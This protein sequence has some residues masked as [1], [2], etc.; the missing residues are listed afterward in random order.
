MRLAL[1]SIC[2]L[3]LIGTA[4]AQTDRGTI[5]GT[6]ADPTGAMIGGATIIA[7]NSQTA[8]EYTAAS[9]ATGNYTLAQLPAGTYEI[10]ASMSGFKK[11]VRPG[12]VVSVAQVVRVDISLEVGQISEL[13]T[14]Q[15][16]APLLKTESGEMS[17][18]ISYDR[19]DNL[20][21]ITLGG[22]AGLG[23]IRNPLQVITLLP[24]SS[25][26]NDNT[27][28]ING[29]PSSS[30]AIRIE[31]QD[32]T[33]GMWRQQNQSIQSG[34]DAI[35]EVSI[36]TSNFAAEYGQA[37]GGYFNYTMKSGTNAVHGSAYDY[38]VNEAYNAG[39]PF[40]NDGTG[41]HIK[42]RQRRND[43]G[44]T[45]GGPIYIPKVYNGKDKSFFFFNFEQ[46][47][48][49]QT[50]SN[51][52]Q[53]MPTDAYRAGDF[54]AALGN[55]LTKGGVPVVD[56][57]GRP[58][59]ENEI[60]NPNSTTTVNGVTVRN[61]FMGCNNDPADLNKICTNPASPNYFPLD[62]VAVKMQAL[63]PE[64]NV[65]NSVYNNYNVPSYQN[66]RHTTITSFK[67]DHSLSSKIKLSGYYSQ[68]ITRSPS[69]NG[70]DQIFSTAVPVDTHSRTMRLNFDQTITPTM[71]F[72]FGVGLLY[73][74]QPGMTQ[75]VDRNFF[76][77]T[78]PFFADLFPSAGIT[79]GA[80]QK[81]GFS[82]GFSYGFPYKVAKDSKPTANTSLTWV[83]GNHTIKAGGELVM[84]GLPTFNYSRAG[85][86][87]AFGVPETALTQQDA[88]GW[89]STTGLGYAS[90][91]L[92]RSDSLQISQVTNARLGNHSMAFFVQDTWKVTRKLTLDYGLRWD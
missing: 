88:A 26:A 5:T 70:F 17:H 45:F 80:A 60:Y 16:D 10:S 12:I 54:S 76:G 86:V 61:P 83:R 15:A 53:T 47:R 23:N 30:Q 81:G 34:L 35:Q 85:G 39:T 28:R 92:G 57:L 77:F 52:I 84:E 25:F 72:H 74:T 59:R 11:Y 8:A 29:M 51:G 38:N 37:G 21:L 62:P 1:C 43:Y 50:I 69:A 91:L 71:L 56:A 20:P 65:P 79:M 64:P 42:N 49:A 19:V 48:E 82:Y 3:L 33:N 66:F 32:A 7:K 36:Q 58:V 13:V 46:F 9:T 22:A 67:I 73:T 87:Y 40:T 2:V 4:V 55:Q 75:T 41:G 78:T 24:G 6:I 18:N 27:L 31:G 14:V 90:F 68:T 63:L 44:F 89:N